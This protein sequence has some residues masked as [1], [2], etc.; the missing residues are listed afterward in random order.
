MR[1]RRMRFEADG[2]RAMSNGLD[3]RTKKGGAEVERFD[4]NMR[5][6]KFDDAKLEDIAGA[7]AVVSLDLMP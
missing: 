1:G 2:G 7:Y 5:A 4:R 3:N 6:M